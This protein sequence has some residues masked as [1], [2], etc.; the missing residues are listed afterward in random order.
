MINIFNSKFIKHGLTI[1]YKHF[2]TNRPKTPENEN[3]PM[4][5]QK[6]SIFISNVI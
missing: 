1:Q 4:S 5:V 3:I 2:S 6:L